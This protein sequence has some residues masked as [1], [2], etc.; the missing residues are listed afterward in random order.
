MVNLHGPLSLFDTDDSDKKGSPSD[1][2]IAAGRSMPSSPSLPTCNLAAQPSI[3]RG[4]EK[5]D[6]KIPTSSRRG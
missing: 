4:T 6:S 2:D 5:I 3:G 1:G